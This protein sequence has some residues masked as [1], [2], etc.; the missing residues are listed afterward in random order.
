MA[1]TPQRAFARV[2]AFFFDPQPVDALVLA[3]LLL[4]GALFS[5]YAVR[6]PEV[7]KLFGPAGYAG[8]R[9][10]PGF[11]PRWPSTDA[12]LR[13][14]EQ[15]LVPTAGLI[16]VLYAALLV[17]ALCFTLGYRMRLAGAVALAL[18]VF[19]RARLPYAFWGWSVHIQP[20]LLYVVCSRAGAFASIDAWRERRRSGRPPATEAEWVAPAWPLRLLM[21][22]GCTMYLVSGGERLD[23]AGWYTGQG[24]WI[25]MSNTLYSKVTLG[26]AWAKPIFTVATLGVY[27]LEATAPVLLWVPVTRTLVAYLSIAMHLALEVLTLVGYWNFCMVASL[28][29]FLPTSHL[30]VVTR[31]LP[32]GP[33]PDPGG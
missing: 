14:L 33:R 26:W 19:F 32:G 3:R 29:G 6:A 17:A 25:A 4:G 7:Q 8:A 31:R 28:V 18:H 9:W 21:I 5:A 1:L 23:D 13:S 16:W 2:E 20:L 15:V 10:L 12:A 27:L 24:I 22:T 30:R 11:E